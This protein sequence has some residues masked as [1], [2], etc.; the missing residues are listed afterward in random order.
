[1]ENQVER[2]I[3]RNLDPDDPDPE[4][5]EV[6]SMCMNCEKNVCFLYSGIS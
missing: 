3:F 5:T 1:M 6:E 4:A 2:P